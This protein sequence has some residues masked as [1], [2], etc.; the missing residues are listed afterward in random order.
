MASP[1]EPV[2]ATRTT[3]RSFDALQRLLRTADEC[4]SGAAGASIRRA[5]CDLI[6][7]DSEVGAAVARFRLRGQ[8][9]WVRFRRACGQPRRYDPTSRRLDA[10]TAA[11]HDAL[12]AAAVPSPYLFRTC[13]TL[14]LVSCVWSA[15]QMP[16]I[17]ESRTDAVLAIDKFLAHSRTSHS[18]AGTRRLE[19]SGS[20]QRGWL[21]A[22]TDF[23]PEAGFQYVVTAEG[24][25]GYI[26]SRVL[27]SLLEEERRLIAEGNSTHVS[28]SAAN[29]RF[30][31][32]SLAVEGLSRVA[33]TPRRKERAL[34]AGHLFLR[35]DTGELVRVEGRLAKNPSFW[36]TRVEIVRSYERIN[37]ALMPVLL[38]STAQLRFLGRSAL[39]MTYEY[40][41]IDD[42]PIAARQ[43][44]E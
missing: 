7:A 13:T 8:I 25:S 18:Y 22:R 28:L 19:A 17:A 12:P 43:D 35:P 23:T 21:D 9:A 33:M 24:G 41:A 3:I 31:D 29:Y 2:H 11:L 44:S 32:E 26:R 39:R 34:I 20:G 6:E 4:S 40:S 16:G 38:E 15:T 5:A 36:V 42:Q 27:R 30:G 10:L 14:V 1:E 37:D